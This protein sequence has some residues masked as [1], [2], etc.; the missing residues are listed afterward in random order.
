M[1]ALLA[2]MIF[3]SSVAAF[4]MTGTPS[5]EETVDLLNI[6]DGLVSE[7]GAAMQPDLH[8]FARSWRFFGCFEARRYCIRSANSAGYYDVTAGLEPSNCGNRQPWACY[9]RR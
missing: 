6:E 9:V 8:V 2:L 7:A 4:A 1:K 5:H 3:C